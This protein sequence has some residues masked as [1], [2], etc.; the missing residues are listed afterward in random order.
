MTLETTRNVVRKYFDSNHSDTSIMADDVVF[1]VMA[2]G[3][4]Y[5]GID[6]VNG[7]LNDFYHIAFDATATTR[8]TLFGESNAMI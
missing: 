5:K 7:M 4:Q 6:A 1:T 3:G 8:T 2:T